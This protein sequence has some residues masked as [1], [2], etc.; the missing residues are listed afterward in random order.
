MQ[1]SNNGEAEK[2]IL[3]VVF[4]HAFVSRR[5]SESAARSFAK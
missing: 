3:F 1:Q 2:E 4:T 5:L